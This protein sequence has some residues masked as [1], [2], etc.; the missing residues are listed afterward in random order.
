MAP[1]DQVTARLAHRRADVEAKQRL[2]AEVL[3]GMGCEAAVLLMPAHVA[4]FTAGLTARGL[5][6][7]SERPGVFTNGRQRWLLCSN[8]DTH[9]LFDEE[10]DR[11]GFQLKEWAWDGG[12]SELLFNVTTGRT[13][14]ADRPFPNVPMANDR[15]RP[16]LRALSP[17]EQEQ[18]R[19][20]GAG[21]AH[22]V[23]ATARGFHRH[24]SEEE[25]AGQL[26]HRLLHRGIEPAVL[27]VVADA[28]G[29]RFRRAGF[30]AAPV[31]HTC[32]IQATGQR[33]GLYATAARTVTF[34]P[35]PDEFRTGFDLALKLAAVYRSFTQP[36][37]AVAPVADATGTL[38]ANTPFEFDAR[39]S[40]PGYGA[41]RFAAEELRRAGAD[42]PL[43]A[44]QA[45]VWQPR[46][47]PAACADTVIVTETGYEPVT[48]PSEW[49]FKRVTVRGAAHDV[50]DLLVRPAG[51]PA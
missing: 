10:L 38:L 42:E 19:E 21:V 23:E 12:R 29:A 39:L 43:V 18:Y 34:G 50:P 13:V 2:V 46:V 49:P 37:I 24:E 30:T 41:G 36:G 48:P 33:D 47:G 44:G 26:G 40:Q 32:T 7:D 14:A 51:D 9:R 15:L 22:A 31:R 20:L 28:R 25:V 1:E 17:F 35:P 3:A 45:V 8:V 5:I 16:L 27:S 11:L 6:A 4:W